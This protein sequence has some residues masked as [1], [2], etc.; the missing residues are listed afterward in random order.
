MFLGVNSTETPDVV[1]SFIERKQL[2]GFNSLFD[3]D[4]SLMNGMG[5]GGIPHTVVIGPSGEVAHVHVGYTVGAAKEVAQI[6]RQLL[7]K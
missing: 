5:I 6:V 3:F 2:E 1:R 7:Q 4:Q